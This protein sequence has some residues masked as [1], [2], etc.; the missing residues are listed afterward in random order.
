MET[1][2]TFISSKLNLANEKKKTKHVA[3]LY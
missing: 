3:V 2:F 1:E